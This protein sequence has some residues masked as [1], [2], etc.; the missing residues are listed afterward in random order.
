MPAEHII[1]QLRDAR[2]VGNVATVETSSVE[3]LVRL[4]EAPD[5]FELHAYFR[6]R[7]RHPSVL[8][9]SETL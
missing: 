2:E 7:R 9:M 5:R 4:T 3:C 1:K 8:M 6:Q